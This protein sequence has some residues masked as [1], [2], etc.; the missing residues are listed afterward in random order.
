MNK[1]NKLIKVFTYKQD[2]VSCSSFYAVACRHILLAMNL[3]LLDILIMSKI[4]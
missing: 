3:K 1:L 4:T 2:V